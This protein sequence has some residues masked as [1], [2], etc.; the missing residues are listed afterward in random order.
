MPEIH[1][2]LIYIKGCFYSYEFILTPSLSRNLTVYTI[3]FAI[4]SSIL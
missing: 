1:A 4:V 3:S 2:F